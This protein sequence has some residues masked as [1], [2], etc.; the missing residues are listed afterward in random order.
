MLVRFIIQGILEVFKQEM[1][2]VNFDILG[3]S[4]QKWTRMGEFNWDTIISPSVGKNPLVEM[5]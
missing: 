4:E 1:A 5:E 3:I 2:R